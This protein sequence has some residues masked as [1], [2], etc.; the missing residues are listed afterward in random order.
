M[1]N[2][3]AVKLSLSALKLVLNLARSVVLGVMGMADG[4]R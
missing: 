1:R 3:V 2:L 4:F